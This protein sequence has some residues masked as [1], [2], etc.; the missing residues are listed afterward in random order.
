MESIYQLSLNGP[1][2]EEEEDTQKK[3][4]TLRRRGDI[5]IIKNKRYKD[6]LLTEC[7]KKENRNKGK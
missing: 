5:Y 2:M 4:K 3:E 7:K 1:T 6:K